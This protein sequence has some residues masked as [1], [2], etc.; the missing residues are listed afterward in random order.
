MDNEYL[1]R[2][3]QQRSD[4]ILFSLDR[5]YCLTSFTRT[6]QE[7]LRVFWHAEIHIGD[8][9]LDHTP[10]Q[11]Q[12][13]SQSYFDRALC[14]EK[15][16]MIEKGEDYGEGFSYWESRF[17]PIPDGS[18]G[19]EG[20]SVLVRDIT[21]LVHTSQQL[22]ETKSRLKL[23][24][25]A[26]KTGVWEWNIRTN[27][28]YWSDEVYELFNIR[29]R[30]PSLDYTSYLDSVHPED[31]KLL[32][33]KIQEAISKLSAYY[34][35]HRVFTPN[36][37]LRWIRGVGQI[38]PGDDGR[39]EKLTGI[40]HDI[41]Q[42]KEEH[43]KIAQ[44]ALVAN[45]TT[46]MV[47]ITDR[48]G[49]VEWV[50]PAFE[51]ITGY[52]LLEVLGKKPGHVLQGELTDKPTADWISQ[53]IREGQG[54][55]NIELINYTKSGRLYWVSLEVIPLT[56]ENGQVEKFVAVQSDITEQKL[57]NEILRESESRFRQIIQSSPMGVLMYELNDRNELVLI[58]TNAS[59]NQI[60][61]VDTS[62]LLGL[63]IEQAFPPLAQTEIP[64]HYRK[65]ARENVPWYSEEVQY[66][67]GK[68]SGA[69][70]VHAFQAGT[71]RVAIFFL[72]ITA[73][74]KSEKE[75]RDWRTRYELIVQSS[76]QM[77]YDYDVD[78]GKILWSGSTQEIL[79]YTNE[80]M[81]D[82]EQWSMLIHRDDRDRIVNMLMTAREHLEKFNVEYR[83][84]DRWGNY[85][86]LHDRGFFFLDS[87]RNNTMRMLGIMEDITRAKEAEQTLLLNNEAL[88]KANEELDRFVY[89]ASHD[90][91]A[92]IASLLG[93]IQVAKMEKSREA[94]DML[95]EMQEKSLKRLDT[96]IRDIVDHS[97][98]ARI[99]VEYQEADL[100]KCFQEAFDQVSF[101]ENSAKIRK[102]I[103]IT[104]SHPFITDV[105]RFQIIINNLVSN[106]IKYADLN[107]EDPYLEVEADITDKRGIFRIHDN[108]EGIPEDLHD[109]IFDMFFRASSRGTGSGLGLYIVKEVVNRLDG[110]VTVNAEFGKGSSFTVLL[111]NRL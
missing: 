37:Q 39:P 10:E 91:R 66:N 79:G 95:F 94:L 74:K 6:Y 75:I 102:K 70:Q 28:V 26:S 89:S 15:F 35:E 36:N 48:D 61:G 21:E 109:Q 97:R 54:F 53:K 33:D 85:K 82:I 18:G 71:N 31:V 9:I 100:E 41:T 27:E 63:T 44:L 67:D 5:N 45:A 104:Q 96:F 99:P 19:I 47:I 4:L 24:L 42:E 110:A 103:T 107:K 87:D 11:W 13:Q 56:D 29:D 1:I 20:I 49:R 105:K 32:Q 76:R 22:D 38:I 34:V 51:H 55:K 64:Q 90:L 68:I 43:D 25:T 106:A 40:V 30:N 7:M 83:F 93:L 69:Y 73:R 59:A 57:S 60:L 58:E 108:G 80:E 3:I 84:R 16:S 8:N 14:G 72:D 98:N 50:N 101:M 23:A 62:A 92:P 88:Q 46:N 52:T 12:K 81:G 77:I 78:S 17:T 2:A 111:P 86:V 65:A